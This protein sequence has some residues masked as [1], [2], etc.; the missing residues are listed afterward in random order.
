M[1]T[2]SY[3]LG[4]VGGVGALLV[5]GIACGCYKTAPTG[6]EIVHDSPSRARPPESISISSIEAGYSDELSLKQRALGLKYEP[7][8]GIAKLVR[9]WCE[10]VGIWGGPQSLHIEA[11]AARIKHRL[12]HPNDYVADR[13]NDEGV[14]DRLAVAA[15]VREGEE[16]V[17]TVDLERTQG[18]LGDTTWGAIFSQEVAMNNL[19]EDIAW[20]IVFELTPPG[21]DDEI[22]RLGYES[23]VHSATVLAYRRGL[24]T[25]AD[26]FRLRIIRMNI[27]GDYP[28][29]FFCG[30]EIAL[31]EAEDSSETFLECSARA[32]QSRSRSAS[33]DDCGVLLSMSTLDRIRF[34][35]N[36]W[37]W[38]EQA[39]KRTAI[40]EAC[41]ER[42]GKVE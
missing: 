40:Y 28:I 25:A 30:I 6:S 34:L 4:I 42:S 15:E 2:H 24:L 35:Y 18:F 38:R 16:V 11:R 29:D 5:L 31:S 22:I 26:Y 27:F 36:F 13:E 14:M 41:K 19:I 20:R 21:Y 3:D 37:P 1:R 39:R 7:A 33:V 8:E 17:H 10:R 12:F 32:E 9:K 23:Y